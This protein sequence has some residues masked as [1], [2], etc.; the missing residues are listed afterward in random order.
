MR[1]WINFFPELLLIVSAILILW[2]RLF[3]DLWNDEIYSIKYFICVPLIQTLTDYHV[4]NNHIFFNLLNNIY[5]SIL[6]VKDLLQAME[7]PF[8]LRLLPFL[9]AFLT[10][11]V[12]Y[13]MALKFLNR[14]VGLIAIALLITNLTF[15][16][17]ALQIRGYG[18]STLVLLT[19]VYFVFSYLRQQKVSYVLSIISLSFA[20]LLTIPSN[21][22]AFLGIVFCLGICFSQKV[23]HSKKLDSIYFRSLLYMF[24][25]L[26]FAFLVYVPMFKDVFMNEYVVPG[27][28]FDFDK[29]SRIFEHVI[30]ASIGI[31]WLVLILA[32]MGF[33]IGWKTYKK[34]MFLLVTLFSICF[35]PMLLVYLR[36]DNAPLR[37]FV[38]SMPL[39]SLLFAVG[40]HALRMRVERIK[41]KWNNLIVIGFLL[42]GVFYMI[43]EERIIVKELASDLENGIRSQSLRKQYYTYHYQP[44]KDLKNFHQNFYK[45]EIPVVREGCEP[46]GL[47]NFLRKFNIP[48]YNSDQKD[49][50]LRIYDSLHLITNHPY[51]LPLSFTHKTERLNERLTYHNVVLYRK[52]LEEENL[53]VV[54]EDSVLFQQSGMEVLDKT[55]PYS[56]NFIIDNEYLSK[57]AFICI[58]AQ[59]NN[60]EKSKASLVIEVHHNNKVVKWL[61]IPIKKLEDKEGLKQYV[62]R[63]DAID[64]SFDFIKV[65]FWNSHQE[66]FRLVHFKYQVLKD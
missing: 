1:K 63:M 60:I 38:V 27:K 62:L 48:F 9:Y 23:I 17:F 61:G 59:F 21:L 6:G 47:P 36:G 44:M 14:E 3:L 10:L 51:S 50:L 52:R 4:P 56:S 19:L 57:E 7:N 12:L 33:L 41:P 58:N 26:L 64:Y 2:K 35:L 45:K 43:K 8:L 46:R 54:S 42:Y 31:K 20:L 39:F 5:Y 16:N 53:R 11:I 49:S 15:L 22:Y 32:L 13:K 25:G 34:W 66:P 28:A 55:N 37:I 24:I 30:G 29:L 65:Y 18:L 40:I